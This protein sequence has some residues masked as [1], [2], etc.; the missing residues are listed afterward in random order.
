MRFTWRRMTVV[1]RKRQY[2]GKDD[3]DDGVTH[4]VLYVF[5]NNIEKHTFHAT[6]LDMDTT[7]HDELV[8]A[9]RAY[10]DDESR[11]SDW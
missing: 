10:L 5:K 7:P 11:Q 4:V 3:H 8:E 9:L 2:E 6:V 1:M